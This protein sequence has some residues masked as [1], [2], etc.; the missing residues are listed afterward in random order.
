LAP[1]GRKRAWLKKLYAEPWDTFAALLLFA[2]VSQATAMVMVILLT[3]PLG[4]GLV[5]FSLPLAFLLIT[6]VGEYV[7]K[8]VVLHH[9]KNL[10]YHLAGPLVLFT[11]VGSPLYRWWRTG[12]EWFF[13]FWQQPFAGVDQST[14]KPDTAPLQEERARF[15]RV[16]QQEMLYKVAEFVATKASE[17]MTP[18]TE[19]FSLEANERIVDALP[20]VRENLFSRV[21]VY[22]ESIDNIVGILYAKDLLAYHRYS[23][24]GDL[25]VKALLQ[26]PFFV[27]DSKKVDELLR[28][29]QRN[30]IHLAIVVDEY[31]GVA[32][33]VTME[34]VLEE[35][36]GEI[37]DEYDQEE[38][39]VRANP[40]GEGYLIAARLSLADFNSIMHATLPEED[41]DTIGGYVFHQ[42]GRV[43][44][45]GETVEDPHFF[46]TIEAAEGP[47]ILEI[48]VRRK[49]A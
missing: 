24:G 27:P 47:K 11:T 37:I 15:S 3:R 9:A 20:K 49:D 23:A 38:V 26:P 36:V 7:P 41:F 8:L 33:L 32:G 10:A 28:E 13:T 48:H 16:R 6:F 40:K 45:V 21:P 43:P 25:Q 46:F 1:S 44:Q 19:I 18:R 4:K 14:K 22:E 30:K 34:D 42:F 12:V 2:R 35:L 5:Y 17:I 39:L 29:F 31:G